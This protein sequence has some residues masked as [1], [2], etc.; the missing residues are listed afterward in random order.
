MSYGGSGIDNIYSTCINVHIRT[1]KKRYSMT[2][3]ARIWTV[4]MIVFTIVV[5]CIGIFTPVSYAEVKPADTVAFGLTAEDIVR[6]VIHLEDNVAA[7][8]LEMAILKQKSSRNNETRALQKQL[9]RAKYNE[10]EMLLDRIQRKL[11]LTKQSITPSSNT[12][13]YEYDLRNNDNLL[14][15]EPRRE[16]YHDSTRL[17]E[18]RSR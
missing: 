10:G 5:I 7:L 9:R 12:L 15:R 14:I 6:R 1:G 3:G 17:M 16:V 2:L 4:L 8:K 13:R 11:Y 18:R